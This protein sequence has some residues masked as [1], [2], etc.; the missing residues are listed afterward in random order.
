VSKPYDATT[1]DLLET[2]P[3]DWLAFL[4]RPATGPV[5]LIDADV[6]T[7]TAQADKVIRI[8]EDPPWLLHLELQASHEVALPRRLLRYNV[9]LAERHDLPVS[10]AVILLRPEANATALTGW[11]R[12]RHRLDSREHRF[13]YYVVRLWRQPV[14]NILAGGIGTL[15]L[16][17]LASLRRR[18]LPDVL[19]RMSDRLTVESPSDDRKKLW[20][21]AYVLMGLRYP[22]TLI[23]HLLEGVSTME[24]SVT[25]QA[26][27][28]KGMAQG[29]IQGAVEEA[30]R[31][32]LS[33]GRK[34]LGPPDKS[35][36]AAI[37]AIADRE[38][39]EQLHERVFDVDSWSKLF[40]PPA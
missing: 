20:A 3:A 29:V 21:A 5:R 2:A 34:K 37:A 32:L 19:H 6:S 14:Q 33:A 22:E 26:I 40:A 15:P 16:A 9:L 35:T 12:D 24:E 23:E 1:K 18:D 8:D 38:R 25:Y 10:S 30:Q 7:I 39:L 4:G 31:L 17:P 13:P 11:H 28:R 27:I 36:Q